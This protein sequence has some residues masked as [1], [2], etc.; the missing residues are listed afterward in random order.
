[1]QNM[2]RTPEPEEISDVAGLLEELFRLSRR[3]TPPGNYSLTVYSALA[4]L[5]RHGDA[6]LTALA[7]H[8]GVSQPSMTQAVGRLKREGLV[9][10]VPDPSDGRAVLISI[11]D[12]GLAALAARSQRRSEGVAELLA[13]LDATDQ[14]SIIAAT[15]ALRRLIDAAPD[16]RPDGK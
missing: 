4:S 3:L 14:H 11:T 12:T 5:K 13:A 7:A 15:G 1:M 6:R 8:E 2:T 16:Q 9:Q 10:Q